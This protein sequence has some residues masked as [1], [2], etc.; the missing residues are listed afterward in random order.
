MTS[1]FRPHLESMVPYVPGE[2]PRPA[3]RLIKLNTNENPHGPSPKVRLAVRRAIANADLRLYPPPNSDQLIARA[4][5]IYRVPRD[6]ILAGNGS[7]EL[8]EMLFRAA[9]DHTA[10]AAWAFP[11]YSLYDTLAAIQQARV[12]R[13]AYPRNWALPAAALI[14]ARANLTIVCNPNSP[15]G[16]FTPVRILR[17][18]ATRLQPRLLAIDEAYVDFASANALAMVRGFSNVIVLR[19]LSK[20][21]SMAGARV[22][23]AFAQQPIINALMTVKDS[24]NMSRLD[25][26]AAC[27]ALDDLPWTRRN[28]VRICA[29]RDRTVA[30]LRALGFEVPDSSAN[31]ILARIP[32]GASIAAASDPAIASPKS[33]TQTAA[34]AA[35][36][37]RA[38][39][40]DGSLEPAAAALR[41]RGILVRY[42]PTPELRDSLRI[43]V[44]TPAQMAVLVRSLRAIVA[45][46]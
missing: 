30:A 38:R 21:F 18:L 36:A 35:I 41:K 31:F 26:A 1:I 3:Q 27:G 12:T 28:I 45:K 15:S 23:L 16:T 6:M 24:Y 37:I 46:A 14:K 39:F 17:D 33:V 10:R 7:D 25:L 19:T 40:R 32:P 44:G 11:T 5:K 34:S 22:G 4:S 9:L 20:S 13:V 8:L 29:A 42:F 43:T 2:Q